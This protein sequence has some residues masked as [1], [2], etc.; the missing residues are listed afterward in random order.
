MT[1]VIITGLAGK[2]GIQ[3]LDAV[4]NMIFDGNLGIVPVVDCL[5]IFICTI[6]GNFRC[7]KNR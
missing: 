7:G 5:A 3:V 4:V 2:V 1:K 6:S